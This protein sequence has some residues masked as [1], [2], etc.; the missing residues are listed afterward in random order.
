VSRKRITLYVLISLVPLIGALWIAGVDP[1]YL[2]GNDV[3]S[4]SAYVTGDLL[5]AS[6]PIG[7]AV[8]RILTDVGEPVQTGQALAYLAAA[9]QADRR[10]PLVPPVRSPGPGTVVHVS[11]LV[12]ENVAAGQP[13]AMIADLQK[14]WVVAAVDESAFANIRPGQ[15]ADVYVPA[16][17]QTFS[18]RVTQLLP[19]IQAT[20]PRTGSPSGS[21]GTTS[22]PR[23]AGEVPVRVDFDYGAAFVYPGMSADVTIY[24]RG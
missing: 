5:Q 9:P 10:V 17:N 22:A 11:V 13:I 2:L 12:G 4:T 20:V 23:P 21:T 24:V 14:L 19:D 15:R 3:T 16:L 7:G 6:A 8:T 18:G 1:S